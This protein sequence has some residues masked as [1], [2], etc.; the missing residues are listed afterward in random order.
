MSLLQGCVCACAGERRGRK[1]A[2][3][4]AHMALK[5]VGDEMEGRIIQELC[6]SNLLCTG[7]KSLS[8]SFYVRCVPLVFSG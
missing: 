7:N 3:E 4:S 1:Y 2:N 8:P 5:C 6:S